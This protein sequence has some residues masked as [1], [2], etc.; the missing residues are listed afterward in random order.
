VTS[1]ATEIYYVNDHACKDLE[2]AELTQW[3]YRCA[4]IAADILTEA[5]YFATLNSN[6][7]LLH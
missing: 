6:G 2:D 7:I 1:S 3:L 4:G 5:E